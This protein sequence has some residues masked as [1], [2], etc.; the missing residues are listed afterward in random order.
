M[1]FYVQE[2]P[3]LESLLEITHHE[4]L[5]PD[6]IEIGRCID[7]TESEQLYVLVK[8]GNHLSLLCSFTLHRKTGDKYVC[9]QFDFPLKALSWFPKALEDFRRPP[10]E[11]GLHA[12]AMI[13][14]DEDVDGEMLCV[15][16]TTDGYFIIN[17]SRQSPLAFGESYKPTDLSLSYNFLYHLGFLDLWK[18]LGEKY[19]RGEL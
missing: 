1:S 12:G 9:Y 6:A 2:Y 8:Q 17:W 11:G 15:G 7:T 10:A 16:S 3:L 14:S 4:N 19:E 18:R 5:P 13:S